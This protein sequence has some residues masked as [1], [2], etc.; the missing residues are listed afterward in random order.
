MLPV[1]V[2]SG[3][4]YKRDDYRGVERCNAVPR[5][6]SLK[7]VTDGEPTLRKPPEGAALS[8]STLRPSH[9]GTR[10]RLHNSLNDFEP[11][12]DVAVSI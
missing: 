7:C 5:V 11:T 3:I 6:R 12:Q 1:T 8:L 2:E 4:N 9:P 10:W